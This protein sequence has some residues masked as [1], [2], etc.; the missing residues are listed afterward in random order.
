MDIVKLTQ[1]VSIMLVIVL[2]FNYIKWSSILKS[3]ENAEPVRVFINHIDNSKKNMYN[4]F[5]RLNGVS[6]NRWFGKEI[7]KCRFCEN[8]YLYPVKCNNEI[9]HTLYSMSYVTSKINDQLSL[10][11]FIMVINTVVLMLVT[12]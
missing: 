6:Y 7:G 12:K 2:T 5:Y 1:F 8:S 4:A 3:I 9:K 10:I 11:M